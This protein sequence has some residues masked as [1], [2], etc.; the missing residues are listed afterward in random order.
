MNCAFFHVSRVVVV[1][2]MCGEQDIKDSWKKMYQTYLITPL[3]LGRLAI[4][5]I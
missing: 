3:I 4:T 5:C 1:L 2:Q